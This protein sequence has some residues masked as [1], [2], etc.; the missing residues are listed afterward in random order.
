MISDEARLWRS[1][2]V[3]RV[4]NKYSS[5]YDVNIARGTIWGNPYSAKEY[6]DQAI[7]L[8]KEYFANQIR[9]GKITR[10]H[11]EVLR[12]QRLGCT[13]KPKPCHGDYI[14]TIV[15]KLFKDEFSIEDL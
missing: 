4:V 7:P 14:A 2:E 10:N 6:G 13:C 3:C 5:E 9:S 1:S 11:L 8:F 15:N 12:G